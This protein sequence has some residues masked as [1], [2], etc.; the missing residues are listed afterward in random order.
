MWYEVTILRIYADIPNQHKILVVW[1]L[2]EKNKGN[3]FEIEYRVATKDGKVLWILDKSQLH[4]DDSGI[5]YISCVLID[6][7]TEKQEQ[8]KLRL[9]LERHRIGK[10]Q[11]RP[12]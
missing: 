3:T 8:E 6:I 9:A 7:T 11:Q 5:D 10:S 2:C 12:A 4:T 1:R